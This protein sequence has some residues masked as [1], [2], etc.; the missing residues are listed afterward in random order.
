[1]LAEFAGQGYVM[2]GADYFGMGLSN[3]PEGYVV[4]ASHQQATYDLLIA[5]RAVLD[6][7][8]V[9][10]PKLFLGGWSQGGFVTMAFLEKLEDVGRPRRGGGD[11]LGAGRRLCAG[12]RRARFPAQE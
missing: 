5:S 11:R 8:G 2:V 4:K 10:T 9:S 12:Q 3:E 6:H 1:M 7:M